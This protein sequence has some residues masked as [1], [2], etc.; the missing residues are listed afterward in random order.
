MKKIALVLMAIALIS[1][2]A[3]AGDMAKSGQWG[4]QTSLGVGTSPQSVGSIG[5]KFMASENLAIRVKAGFVSF[6]PPVASG[7]SSSS[8]SGYEVGAGFEYHME[9]KGGSVSPYVGL[10]FGYGGESL[11]TPS[12]GGTV[13]NASTWAV[14]GVF[15]GEYFFSSNFSWGGEIGIG[16]ANVSTGATGVDAGHA[17]GTTSATSI[18]TW[19]LN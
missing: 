2:S 3:F 15:G 18:V 10:Q 16:Y 13:N 1:A 7:G 4:I 9:S 14:N 6:T 11:P 5:V 17:F 19:Y 8:T 12:G